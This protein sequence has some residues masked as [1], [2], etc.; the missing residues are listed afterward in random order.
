[1]IN[2][3]HMRRWRLVGKA[4]LFVLSSKYICRSWYNLITLLKNWANIW[5]IETFEWKFPEYTSCWYWHDSNFCE[6][7]PQITECWLEAWREKSIA[8]DLCSVWK[9]C[10]LLKHC[11]Y[12]M[13]E[14]WVHIWDLETKH[15]LMEWINSDSTKP[16]MFKTLL[17]KLP[18]LMIAKE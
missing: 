6:M 10:K 17:E 16:F 7:D 4:S 2:A 8:F 14:T 18:F 15:H 9:R 13:N 5:Y 11:C 12:Y 3:L 1:M